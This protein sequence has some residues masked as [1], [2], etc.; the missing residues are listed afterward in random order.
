MGAFEMHITTIQQDAQINPPEPG[1][2]HQTQ[3]PLND[4]VNFAGGSVEQ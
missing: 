4:Q 1:P 2:P 3:T